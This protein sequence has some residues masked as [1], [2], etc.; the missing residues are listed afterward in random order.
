MT[1]TTPKQFN[2]IDRN[3]E[4][5][6]QD[7]CLDVEVNQERRITKGNAQSLRIFRTQSR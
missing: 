2:K 5:N 7:F 6:R 3:F 4:I 1:T